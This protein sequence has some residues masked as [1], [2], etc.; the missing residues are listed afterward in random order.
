MRNVIIALPLILLMGCMPPSYTTKYTTFSASYSFSLSK[1]E[2]PEKATQRYGVQK[3]DVISD[4]KYHFYFED[5]LVKALWTV[6]SRNI[7]FSLQNKTDHSI[8]IPWD[9]ASFID[10]SGSSHRV[11]HSGVKYTERQQPQ[12]PSVIAR[13]TSLEDLVFPTDYVEW[14]EGSSYTAGKWYEKPFLPSFDFHGEY[15]NGTYTTFESFDRDAKS[16]IGKTLQVLLPL[17]IEDVVNEYIFS[18]IV[19]SVSTS[20]ETKN[21]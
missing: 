20:Q 19:D 14:E 2:R 8:K 4:K 18:F 16:K 11:M 10:E 3:I 6:T 1:V 9:E 7:S 17:Q 21:D 13:R 5:D 12:A 15:L